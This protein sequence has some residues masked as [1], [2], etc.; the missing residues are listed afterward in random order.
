MSV[1]MLLGFRLRLGLLWVLDS[2]GGS[3]IGKCGPSSP[4][5]R[6]AGC[7]GFWGV[8][9]SFALDFV[10]PILCP[11]RYRVYYGAPGLRYN[12]DL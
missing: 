9:F 7:F 6:L 12:G 1:G 5:V 3:S 2:C 10:L 11:L 4:Y 8:M